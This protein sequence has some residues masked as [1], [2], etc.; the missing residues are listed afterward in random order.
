MMTSQMQ[1]SATMIQMAGDAMANQL[2]MLQALS[3]SAI[4]LP[5]RNFRMMADLASVP[6]SASATSPGPSPW[7][8]AVPT[9]SPRSSTPV[10]C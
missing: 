8:R 9:S 6:F 5:Y 2:K 1:M 7:G 4:E 3:L 10:G